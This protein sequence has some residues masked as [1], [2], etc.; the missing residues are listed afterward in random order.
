MAAFLGKS[1]TL[2][3]NRDREGVQL[4]FLGGYIWGWGGERPG[5]VPPPQTV[6]PLGGMHFE[7]ESD[8]DPEGLARMNRHRCSAGQGAG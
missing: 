5:A 2:E 1:V 4:E 7:I 6:V 8:G 3:W